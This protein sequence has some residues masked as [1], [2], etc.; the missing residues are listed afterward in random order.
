MRCC[1]L[2]CV[3]SFALL[4]NAAPQSVFVQNGNIYLADKA[5]GSRA[6]T[7]SGLD[8]QP[9]VSPD[10][11]WVVF[12]RGTPGKAISTGSADSPATELWQT[13]AD[14]KNATLLVRGRGSDKTEAVLANFSKP[15]FSSDGRY[16]FF[17]SDAW[18]TSGAVHIVDTTNR[19]EHFVCPGNDLDVVPSGE[20]RDCLLVLQH[21]YFIGG[22]SYDWYWLLRPNGKEIGPVGESTENFKATYLP[23]D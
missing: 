17:L 13:G 4:E 5:G 11:R 2:G 21:R 14:G 12:V 19:K 6:L 22:G 1:V 10:R 9:I 3:L 8:S 7:S 20:Y 18:A 16:V 15:K 23:N